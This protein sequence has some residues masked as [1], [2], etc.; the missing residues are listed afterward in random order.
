MVMILPLF[1]LNSCRDE[2]DKDWTTPEAGIKLY[3][4]TLSSNVLYP[5]MA[6][7]AFRLTWDPLAGVSGE[8]TVQ[9]S[10]TA[11]FAT[12]VVL[13]TTTKTDY[14]TKISTLN[15]ALLQAGFS[16][17]SSNPVFIRVMSGTYMS[18]IISVA[19]TPYP[20]D[21]PV[22]TAPT[23]GQS[24]V[25][26]A[27]APTAVATTVKWSDYVY[28][29]NVSYNVEI[30]P[31]G[32]TAFASAGTTE[33]VKELSWT[34]FQLND[35]VL[36]LGGVVGVAKDIQIKVTATTASAGGTINKTS[37][38]VTFK[39]TPYQPAFVDFYLVGG[40]TAV[41][42]NAT[43]SQILYRNNDVA[44]IYTYLQNEGEFRF[45]GQQDWN[46]INYSLNDAAIKDNFKFFNTWS[47]SLQPAGDENIKFTGN[48]GMYK[49]TIDQNSRGITVTP[50][51]I[52]TLP[53][54]VYLVGSLTGW[55]A[56]TAVEMNQV[57][58]GVYELE[59][60]VPANSEFKFIGQQAWGDLEWANIHT[61]GNS[62]FLGPKGDNNNIKY[63]GTGGTYKITANIK[64]G[65]Y[66]VSPL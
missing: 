3:N 14:T 40:G 65:T 16:P 46:P 4:S 56:S 61:D 55:N 30:A 20:V 7:N 45:L 1:L 37:D 18:N 52:P 2:T 22:I 62:G 35:A 49:I 31:G 26:N 19:V 29:T 5:S 28:G 64:L 15:M 47:T 21:K 53:T 66:S 27:T 10:K 63:N 44:E 8:Y 36:K 54:N 60:A 25:L 58:D 12:P 50:S 51:A 24:I 38:I 43:S 13:G 39:V 17:Y 33:N 59:I 6:D 41:G 23:A 57:G 32:S 48:S 42:W 9:I 34:N 11:D